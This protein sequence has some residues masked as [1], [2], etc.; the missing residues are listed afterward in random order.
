MKKINLIYE[1]FNNNRPLPNGLADKFVSKF[2]E[3]YLWA[4]HFNVLTRFAPT[5]K[6]R[7][8]YFPLLVEESNFDSVVKSVDEVNENEI[9]WLVIELNYMDLSL[10]LNN[11]FGCLNDK[12]LDLIRN[13][14]IKLIIYYAYEAFPLWQEQWIRLIEK[15]LGPLHIPSKN[16]FFIFGDK[17][18]EQ[19]YTDYLSRHQPAWDLILENRFSFDHFEFEFQ[20]YIKNLTND[21]ELVR[22]ISNIETKPYR[23]LCLNGGGRPLRLFFLGELFRNNLDQYGLI[24]YLDK[25]HIPI[26][27]DQF[28]KHNPA[29]QKWHEK[30]LKDL[31]PIY[32]DTDENYDQWHNRGMT[33]KNYS[34]SYVNIVTETAPAWPSFFIT[35]KTFKPI[36]NLQPFIIMG[37]P[38]MLTELRSLGYQ[39]FPEIFD[40]SYD[41]IEDTPLRIEMVVNQVKQ[42]CQISIDD[43]HKKYVSVYE[44]LLFNRNLFL[45]KSHSIKINKLL[46]KII[47][48]N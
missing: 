28:M 25:F 16:I 8:G 14:I 42:I 43:L 22:P 12:T 45:Q 30:W 18:L 26:D 11:C 20:N 44:K 24:S 41:N 4:N 21:N 47:E 2:E 13:G 6:T 34:D 27:Y 31:E 1:K 33:A 36:V 7:V 35:E 40:E 48:K 39:T 3:E 15:S 29:K 37:L 9:N 10:I 38:G 23:Y 17:N 46:S 32:L 19:N 5:K